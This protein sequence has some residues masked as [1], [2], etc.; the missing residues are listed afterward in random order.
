MKIYR[1][2][3]TKMNGRKKILLTVL[4]GTIAVVMAGV[5]NVNAK[6]EM[7]KTAGNNEVIPATQPRPGLLIIAHG[8]PFAEWNKPVLDLEDQ[9]IK[10]LGED[11]PFAKVKVC[12]MEFTKPSIAD[13]VREIEEAGCSRI[14]AVPLLI[15]PSSHSH[16]D[17]PALLGIYSDEDMEKELKAEGAEIIRSRLP[18]TVTA[19]LTHSNLVPEIMLDRVKQLSKDPQN[20]A[21]VLLSHGDEFTPPLWEKLMMRTITNICGKTGISYAD[22]GFVHVGQTYATDGV[23]V[24]AEAAANRKK[25]IVVGAYLSMGVDGMHKRYNKTFPMKAMAMPGLTDPLK[26]LDIALAADGLLPDGRVAQWIADVAKRE[27][28]LRN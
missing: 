24:I 6:A 8:A 18:I 12:M 14:I 19:T 5:W 10:L 11:N 25:V 26:G 23:G 27:A 21:V 17:I 4:T 3:V 22:Y 13:G 28:F 16:W 15:A 1:K 7:K 2:D 9:V 20:E